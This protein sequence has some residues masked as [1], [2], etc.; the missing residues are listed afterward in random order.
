[1]YNRA[2]MPIL[3]E[4]T[5]EFISRSPEQTRRLGMRLGE[6]LRGGELLC[7]E[8]ELGAGKTT[9]TQGIATGWGVTGTVRSPTFTLI[10]EFRRP[11]DKHKFYHV[12]LYRIS[13][14]T[15]AWALGLDDIWISG[16]VCIIEWPERAQD[17]L[18]A[19]RIWIRLTALDET[20]RMLRL[21][22]EGERYLELLQAFRRA[23]FGG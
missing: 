16:G 6:L 1:M 20:R 19:E 4:H 21:M 10:H 22:A 14:S 11:G 17:I 8:G 18:P 5:L 9:L 12:D 7:L 13:S 23:A 3:N 15:E 2:Y